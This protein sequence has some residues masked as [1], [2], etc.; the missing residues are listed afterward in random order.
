M[1]AEI[2]YLYHSG[3]AV[4]TERH[5]LIFDYYLDSPHGGGLHSGVIDPE[6]IMGFNVVVF[7]S[8]RHPDHFNPVIFDWRRTVPN[9]R[10]ILSD[11][12]RTKEEAIKVH[13]RREYDLGDLQV[14]TLKSTDV[15]CA[16]LIHA[17]GLCIYHAGDLNLWYWEGDSEGRNH[18]M[19]KNYKERIDTLKNEP[20]DIAFVP[21]DP[22]LEKNCLL[23][24]DYF[25]RTVG[26]N[27]VFSMHFGDD[28]SIFETL[29]SSPVTELYRDQIVLNTDR[30][31]AVSYESS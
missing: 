16:F 20:I 29:K 12:I 10:Y 11:D 15:G 31:E 18:T 23:G 22:R 8:H 28:R 24:L 30:G 3:F 2:F 7:S 13:P 1:E 21:V 5:F 26:A 9:I 17:D 19:E 4:K 27:L 14:R 25:M 6:E